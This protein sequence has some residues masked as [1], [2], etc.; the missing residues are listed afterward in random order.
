MNSALKREYADR[1]Y[2]DTAV[3]AA[4][5]IEILIHGEVFTMRLEDARQLVFK[6]QN[7]I[8]AM[9]RGSNAQNAQ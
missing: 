4:P 7:A 8:I 2:G 9:E 5:V 6:I 1:T 3:V